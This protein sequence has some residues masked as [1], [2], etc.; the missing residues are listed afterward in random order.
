MTTPTIPILFRTLEGG[1]VTLDRDGEYAFIADC[2]PCGDSR[3]D[4]IRDARTWANTHSGG[5]RALPS[6]ALP[7][8]VIARAKTTGGGHIDI[9]HSQPEHERGMRTTTSTCTGCGTTHT[10]Q[11]MTPDI[12]LNNAKAWTWKHSTCP[13]IPQVGAVAGGAP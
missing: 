3:T 9:R 8:G 1:V 12:A 11:G 2:R 7:H 5:C 13:F 4:N 10:E 6:E